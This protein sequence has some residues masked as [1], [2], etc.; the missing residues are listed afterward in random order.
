[1]KSYGK[2]N[3][4]EK[5]GS[6]ESAKYLPLINFKF[7][8]RVFDTVN[9]SLLILV[10]IYT[11]L[12]LNSQRKWSS[13][14]INLSKTKDG[15]NNLIDYISKTEEF[16]INKLDSLANLKKTTPQD[17]VYL[18][19]ISSKKENLLDKKIQI[20]IKGLEDSR[21]LIGY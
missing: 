2:N 14:Y 1:M 10:F 12:S 20:I 19:K 8:N 21:Y 7:V 13:T 11:F 4:L 16:Y 6:Q 15:N 17:L 5:K 3:Y 18:E 9:V